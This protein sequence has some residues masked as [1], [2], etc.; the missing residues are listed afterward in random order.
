MSRG[1]S[2]SADGAK[3]LKKHRRGRRECNVNRMS[4]T[5]LIVTLG[6][7]VCGSPAF[8]HQPRMV[9]PGTVSVR[10]EQPEVS[11]AYYGTLDGGSQVFE[12][13]SEKRFILYAN[14]LVP[15]VP[16]IRKDVSAEIRN[17]KCQLIRRLD[18]AHSHWTVFHE[19]F[20]GDDYYQ[21]PEFRRRVPAGAYGIT[22]SSP[23]QRSTYVLAIG[24]KEEFP[25]REIART[26]MVLPRLKADFFGKSRLSVL[27]SYA[28]AFLA[29]IV[30]VMVGVIYLLVKPLRRW[31]HTA[32]RQG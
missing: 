8:A 24:E 26:L 27:W 11:K 5:Y 13:R 7:A 30:L 29:F 32:G 22:V 2:I 19:P 31:R 6:L 1:E 28:G 21:G 20:G 10:V 18:A 4:I 9:E 23:D 3:R 16:G 15:K 25:P 12:V 14:V 17:G